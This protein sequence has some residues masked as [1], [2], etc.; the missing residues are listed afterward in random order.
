MSSTGITTSRS[1]SLRVPASTSVISRPPA[2]NL[3]ISSSGR[4]V[5]ESADPLH[6]PLDQLLQPLDA[7]RHVGAALRACNRVHLVDDQRLDRAQHV[8]R[9]RGQHQ[10]ERL[11][12]RDQD[13]G[14][15]LEDLAPFLLRRVAR[16]HRDAHLRLQPGERAAQVPL[17]VVVERLQRRDVEHPQPLARRRAQ[18]VERVEERGQ[19]LARAGRRLDEHV[20]A[21]RDRRPALDLRRRRRVEGALEPVPRRLGED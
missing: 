8:A 21:A 3:P 11:R 5:A 6:R 15:L 17:D 9:L 20:R 19:G 4:C 2:T 10:V 16:A 14:R 12:R 18:P 7:D 13:V 1:S